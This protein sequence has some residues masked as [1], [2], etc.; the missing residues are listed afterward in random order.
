MSSAAQRWDLF[1]RFEGDEAALGSLHQAP[2]HLARFFFLSRCSD[3]FHRMSGQTQP[4]VKKKRINWSKGEIGSGL[5]KR[6]QN[7]PGK[8]R[9][10][11]SWEQTSPKPG[12]SV[13]SRKSGNSWSRKRKLIGR[14]KKA[15]QKPTL[16]KNGTNSTELLWADLCLHW[17]FLLTKWPNLVFS[18]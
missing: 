4:R 9:C 18:I 7:L 11:T 12:K 17:S 13:L 5:R 6:K 3:F 10:Q 16:W 14:T 8:P 15:L 2:E 1:K